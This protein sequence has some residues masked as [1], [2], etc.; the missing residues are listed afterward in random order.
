[1]RVARFCG[2]AVRCFCPPSVLRLRLTLA[3]DP[4][5]S[6]LYVT[7]LQRCEGG[8]EELALGLALGLC[9]S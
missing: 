5:S 9:G 1:M 2:C 3:R 6:A 4:R 8:D 7:V